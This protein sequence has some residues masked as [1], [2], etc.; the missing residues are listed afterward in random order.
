MQENAICRAI[1][2]VFDKAAEGEG[3]QAVIEKQAFAIGKAFAQ[4][5]AETAVN[6]FIEGDGDGY[7]VSEANAESLCL[8]FSKVIL[9]GIANAAN[10]YGVA[11]AKFNGKAFATAIAEAAAYAYSEGYIEGPGYVETYQKSIAQAIAKPVAYILAE[12]LAIAF[13]NQTYAVAY[14]EASSYTEDWVITE[15]ESY[16]FVAGVGFATSTG[17]AD[18]KTEQVF[19]CPRKDY[20]NGIDL[21]SKWNRNSK[22]AGCK[23][24]LFF[25]LSRFFV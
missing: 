3:S 20:T 9:K 14:L 19:P 25:L 24:E 16:S 12:A 15:T 23:Y 2:R 11:K 4:A 8:A 22:Y 1:E 21:C 6:I 7:G 13:E 17:R 5:F 18:A 10:K